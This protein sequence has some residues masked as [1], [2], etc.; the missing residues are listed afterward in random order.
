MPG[1]TL[2]IGDIHGCDAALTTLLRALSIAKSDTVVVLGDAIDRGPGSK[3][4]V[5][6]LLR[7]ARECRLIFILGNHEEMLLDS[8]TE[9]SDRSAVLAWLQYGGAET[10]QSYGGDPENIPVEHVEFFRSAVNFLQ[11]D[12]DIFIHANLEP[13]VPLDQQQVEWL[14]WTHLTGL[15]EPHSSGKRIVCGHTPQKSG[16]PLV[17]PGWI[18]IDTYVCGAG[19]LTCLDVGT[20]DFCQ[21]NQ[22][23]NLRFGSLE[24]G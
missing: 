17:M 3:Q 15:E 20:N 19:W 6:R 13:G 1:R 22:A 12:R 10:L 7:L 11:T 23:G 24:S 2:A 21:A 18:C 14:R 4:V 5:E 8:L 9:V 16:Y